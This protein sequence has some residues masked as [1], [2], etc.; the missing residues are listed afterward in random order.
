[1]LDVE[2]DKIKADRRPLVE[3]YLSGFRR[4]QNAATIAAE[5]MGLP[6]ALREQI[7][8]EWPDD[9]IGTLW[10]IYC[11]LRDD[12]ALSGVAALCKNRFQ[13]SAP[14]HVEDIKYEWER[15]GRQIV[16]EKWLK[17]GPI[18]PCRC[19]TKVNEFIVNGNCRMP[20]E[21]RLLCARCFAV[22]WGQIIR[23]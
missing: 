13:F 5:I 2:G 6:D 1:M 16:I 20:T 21:R 3:Q 8:D 19:G 11:C 17:W 14:N 9:I 7:I 22:V 18:K 15:L 23:W 10:E 4:S 12:K